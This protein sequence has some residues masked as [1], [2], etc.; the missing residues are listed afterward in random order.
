MLLNQSQVSGEDRCLPSQEMSCRD[1]FDNTMCV[2]GRYACQFDGVD[3][4]RRPEDG[5]DP[6]SD[7]FG[8]RKPVF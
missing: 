4:G 3:C 6:S 2:D 7:V 5:A 8:S 1:A